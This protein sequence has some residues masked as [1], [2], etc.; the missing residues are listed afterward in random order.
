MKTTRTHDCRCYLIIETFVGI[1]VE[2]SNAALRQA[3]RLKSGSV[4][5]LKADC[6]SGSKTKHSS[7]RLMVGHISIRQHDVITSLLPPTEPF[8]QGSVLELR[9]QHH[10][11]P[12]TL[13]EDIQVYLVHCLHH[14]RHPSQDEKKKKTRYHQDEPLR[15]AQPPSSRPAAD[16]G[17]AHTKM[18]LQSAASGTPCG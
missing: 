17:K 3:A 15:N 7:K 16:P 9:L 18:L 2:G 6:R 8:L 14:S 4:L 12:L 1:D 5:E 11:D 10:P 13:S